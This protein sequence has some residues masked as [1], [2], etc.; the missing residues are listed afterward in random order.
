VDRNDEVDRAD[1]RRDREDVQR[2]DEQVDPVAGV[3]LGQRRVERPPGLRG[4]AVGE[5]ARVEDDPAEEEEPVGEGVQAREGDIARSDHQRH[6]E[7]SEPGQDRHDDEEDHRHAVHGHQLVVVLGREEALVRMREL[8]AHQHREDPARAE[9]DQARD[10]VEDPDPL[11]VDGR[12]PGREPAA[13]PRHRV[14]GLGSNR[15]RQ[16]PSSRRP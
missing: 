2:E 8:G 11:V 9:E 15:H 3:L 4:A 6:E 7:V 1:Q 10:E 5:E 12:D 14:D 13:V 16:T